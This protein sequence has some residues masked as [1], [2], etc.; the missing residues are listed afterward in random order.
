MADKG[1]NIHKD[2]LCFALYFLT[3]NIYNDQ[4]LIKKI[5]KI[6][7]T[8]SNTKLINYDES[9]EHQKENIKKKL[10]D[11]LKNNEL[12]ISVL[13]FEEKME[14]IGLFSFSNKKEHLVL[15]RMLSLD[16]HDIDIY[17]STLIEIFQNNGYKMR[18]C[19]V[20]DKEGIVCGLMQDKE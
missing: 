8:V 6:Y 16:Y 2:R 9:T 11:S 3:L 20:N 19:Q 15:T 14:K 13:N 4:Q 18:F 7:K 12:F 17:L 10:E 5:E 1:F